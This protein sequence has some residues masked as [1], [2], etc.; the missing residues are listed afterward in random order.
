[1][2]ELGLAR[3]VVDTVV[4]SAEQ[5]GARQVKRVYMSIGRARDIVP[6]LMDL[7][8]KHLTKGTIAEGAELVVTQIPVMARCG[9]CGLIFPVDVFDNNTWKCPRCASGHYELCGG[10]ELDID[11]I[12][13]VRDP[14]EEA[15]AA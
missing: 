11:R 2:H 3:G 13:V 8:F 4:E 15:G 12:E 5:A 7:A 14:K 10:R 1:M 6:D 9:D